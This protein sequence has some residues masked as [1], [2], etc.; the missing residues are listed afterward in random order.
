MNPADFTDTPDGPQT[1]RQ[2]MQRIATPLVPLYGEHEAR[3][4][5]LLVAAELGRCEPAA[6]LADGA[7]AAGFAW[8]QRI[9]EELAAGRPLQYVLGYTEF[10][11]LRIGVQEGVLIPRPETEELVDW[12]VSSAGNARRIL[13]VGTGSGCIAIAL[14]KTGADVTASDISERALEIAA[15]NAEANG[16]KVR[17]LLSDIWENIDGRFDVIVSNPPYI[18]TEQIASLDREVRDFEP[19]CALDG[20]EDGLKFYREIAKGLAAH[21]EEGGILLVEMG[22]EQGEALKAMFAPFGE[23]KIV[24]DIE[25]RDRIAAVR[26]CGKN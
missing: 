22:A 20:G 6:I 2:M 19:H 9:V 18:P 15:R 26:I 24:K 7:A 11:G 3:Q 25:G 13:D 1:R 21:L 12:M 8:P 5:A 14:A 16:A 10:C 23:V 17:F 4:I